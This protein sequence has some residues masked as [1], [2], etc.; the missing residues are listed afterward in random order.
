[1]DLIK[2]YLAK[3]LWDKISQINRDKLKSAEEIRIR[4]NSPLYLRCGK[5]FV[6][7]GGKDEKSAYRPTNKDIEITLNKMSDY[8]V[9]AFN[10]EI[11]RGY[12]TLPGG[13]RVGICGSIVYSR[14]EII[15][16]K[17]I[18][19]L[20]I[21][22]SRQVKGC[23]DKLVKGLYNKGFLNTLII[24]PPACGKTTLLRDIIRQLSNKGICIGLVDE[25]SEIAGTY[26]GVAQNDL[27]SHTDIL[28]GCKKD[29]GMLM[30]LRSM[31]PQIIA[32]DEIG[33]EEELRCIRQI[34]NSGV[35]L[36]C[37]VHATDTDELVKRIEFNKLKEDKLFKRYVVLSSN[38]GVGT[39]DAVYDEELKRLC[40]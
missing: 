2:D 38:P 27:G 40:F 14:D 4:C 39:V 11:K 26:M 32:A 37:T 31:G 12:L 13:Y 10:D 19:S 15:T 34:A 17:N 28:D 22:I 18:S 5:S 30:L 35:G 9:Y 25:R 24:S 36:L 20:N 16:I 6:Y 7:I 29:K 3:S 23:A 8:S 1:M 33:L 21:R